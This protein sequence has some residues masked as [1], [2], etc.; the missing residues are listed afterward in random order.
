MITQALKTVCLDK[1]SL[2]G[3]TKKGAMML[4]I[5][6]S[7]SLRNGIYWWVI[8]NLFDHHVKESP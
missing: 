1:K 7:G 8:T 6:F 2:L 5:L 4:F 3:I